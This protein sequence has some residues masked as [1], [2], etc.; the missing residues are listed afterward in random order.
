[1]TDQG[2]AEGYTAAYVPVRIEPAQGLKPGQFVKVR[3]VRAD[4]QFLY[5]TDANP[6]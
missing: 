6:A 1:V 4:G 2:Q 5:G 3:P